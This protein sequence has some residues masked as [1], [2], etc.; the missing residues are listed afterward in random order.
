MLELLED[1]EPHSH[2][3]IYALNVVAHSR[4]SDLRRKG[5]GIEQWREDDPRTDE[6]TYWYRLVSRPVEE[7]PGRAS[8][9]ALS[10][11]PSPARSGSFSQPEAVVASSSLTSVPGPPSADAASGCESEPALLELPL[12]DAGL[13]ERRHHR[14]AA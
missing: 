4:I 5:Y 9:G 1:G 11:A 7:S 3:E 8:D 14:D 12:R 10:P 6:T 13:V 2:T